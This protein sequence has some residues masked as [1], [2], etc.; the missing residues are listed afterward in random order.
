LITA[1]AQQFFDNS[2]LPA[3]SLAVRHAL[4]LR[5]APVKS[6]RTDILEGISNSIPVFIDLGSTICRGYLL[7]K[8]FR[9]DILRGYLE[10]SAFVFMDLEG[11]RIFSVYT[12]YSSVNHEPIYMY[13]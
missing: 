4:L 13:L 11:K 3:S 9:R 6:F 12:Q 1:L 7:C 5:N 2:R 10:S 8:S